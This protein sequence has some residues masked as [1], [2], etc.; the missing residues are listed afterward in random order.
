M[1]RSWTKK[2]KQ[3]YLSL[4][5]NNSLFLMLI[6]VLA[7]TLR[8]LRWDSGTSYL[9]LR[10]LRSTSNSDVDGSR[11]LRRRSTI[12][13]SS[14]DNP[15]ASLSSV[16]PKS[17]PVSVRISS[18]LER[19]VRLPGPV[20]GVAL[21]CHSPSGWRNFRSLRRTRDRLFISL[22]TP[23]RWRVFVGV[24]SLWSLRQEWVSW[25]NELTG[26]MCIYQVASVTEHIYS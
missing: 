1:A 14:A 26:V 18:K 10:L 3:V 9:G 17:L 8:C 12:F 16:I 13:L 6:A 11:F 20:S 19:F 24:V 7:N 23:V 2:T 4:L 5:G 15:S 22:V 25:L 21:V